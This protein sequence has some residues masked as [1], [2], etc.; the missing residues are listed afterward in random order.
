MKKK[1]IAVIIGLTMILGSSAGIIAHAESLNSNEENTISNQKQENTNTEN[2][3]IEI[4]KNIK[5]SL[6]NGETVSQIKGNMINNFKIDLNNKVANGKITKNEANQLLKKYTE[7]IDKDNILYGVVKNTTIMNDLN[8]GKTLTKAEE[9]LMQI[10]TDEVN[11]LVVNRK[12]T[13]LQGINRIAKINRN[14]ETGKS[15]FVN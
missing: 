8:S 1:F 13:S 4:F 2:S 5:L 14:I 7:G 12:I 9:N 6:E 10:K 3:G 15:I 11:K